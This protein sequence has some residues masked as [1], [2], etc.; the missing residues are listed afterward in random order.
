MRA[1]LHQQHQAQINM[2][3]SLT[4][5]LMKALKNSTFEIPVI[6]QTLNVNKKGTTNGKSNRSAYH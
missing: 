5:S 1:E 3:I 4:F 2:K 6:P